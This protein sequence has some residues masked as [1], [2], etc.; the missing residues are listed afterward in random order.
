MDLARLGR[1]DLA[2]RFLAMYARTANDFELY[3]LVDFYES[4]RACVRA[5]IAATTLARPNVPDDVAEAARGDARRYLLLAQA[6]RRRN[7]LEPVV[8]AVAGGI[9]S[10]KSSLADRL[11]E[12]LSAPIV[13]ADRTRKHMIGLAPTAHAST[14]AWKGAYDLGFSERVYAEVLRRA[15]AVLA[16]GRPVIIDASFRSAASRKAAR[17]L[18]MEHGVPFRLLECTA[19][20]ELCR[21][22]LVAR[23]VSSSVSDAT[24]DIF[25]SF[26]AGY[27]PI[28]ELDPTEHV[29]IDTSR[30]VADAVR[31][32]KRV[33][34]TWPRGLVR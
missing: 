6:A 24:T 22:R 34:E 20:L 28:E 8:V 4:Y 13:D 25:D 17:D 1:V 14:D 29:R 31:Q 5:K 18:A 16:S 2:E 21:Q 15:D 3:R 10:G 9:A 27:E 7:V 30:D 23:D 26:Y 11:G 32:A 12:E 19:P 33:I